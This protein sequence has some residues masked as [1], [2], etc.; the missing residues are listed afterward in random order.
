MTDTDVLSAETIS[1]GILQFLTDNRINGYDVVD[2]AIIATRATVQGDRYLIV[3]VTRLKLDGDDTTVRVLFHA[4]ITEAE[5]V[6]ATGETIPELPPDEL[7]DAP[8]NGVGVMD[9]PADGAT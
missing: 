8:A 7:P 1:R 6:A 9:E 5:P 4:T 2:G 3:D